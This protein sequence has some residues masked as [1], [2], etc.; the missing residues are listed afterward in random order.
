[1][2]WWLGG[3]PFYPKTHNDYVHLANNNNEKHALF[4]D[5][6]VVAKA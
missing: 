5:G 4:F 1:M 6:F 2:L 3:L